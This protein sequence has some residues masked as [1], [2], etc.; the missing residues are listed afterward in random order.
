MGEG[1]GNVFHVSRRTS[2]FTHKA[3]DWTSSE[4][5]RGALF[6]IP[7]KGAQGPERKPRRGVRFIVRPAP[8]LVFFGFSAARHESC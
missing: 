3:V 4:A 8:S 5:L 1:T 7:I 2:S 6:Q